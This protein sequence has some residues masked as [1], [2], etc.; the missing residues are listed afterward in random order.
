MTELISVRQAQLNI[1]SVVKTTKTESCSVEIACDRVLA[2]NIHSPRRLPPFANSSMDGFAVFSADLIGASRSSPVKLPVIMDIPAGSSEESIL[3]VGTTARIFTGAPLPAG[4]D[5][6]IPIEDTDQFSA[7]RA[8]SMPRE[9]TCFTAVKRG[10]NCRPAGEDVELGQMVLPRGRTLQ[11]QDIGLL[12][13]LGIR[14]V[15]VVKQANIALLSSGD[16]L[17]TLDEP[18][19]PA[20]IYDA[21]HYVLRGL[22]QSAGAYVQHLGIA[23]D[24]PESVI[25]TLDRALEN[26]PDLIISSAGV[27]VG[28]FD[29]VHQ[30]ITEHGGLSFWRVNMRPGKPVAFGEYKGIP[31]LGLPGNPVS[32]Y[33]GCMVFALPFIRSL[34]GLP[35]FSQKTIRVVL[36]EPLKSDDGRESYYRGIVREENGKLTASLAGHQGSGNLFSLVQANALLIVPAGVTLIPAGQ[37]VNAWPLETGL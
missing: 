20:K 4:A 35:P 21:N 34:H 28:A 14:H 2:E 1:L 17:L 27:S 36:T 3:A 10:Q 9:V 6:V 26:P 23:R 19:A 30:V 22:L 32:A 5:A 33:I 24:N 29:Y 31:F 15:E 8:Q 12:A 16:E 37:E 7:M 11:P 13:S 25:E 18:P